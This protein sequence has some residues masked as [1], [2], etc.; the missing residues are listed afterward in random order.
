MVMRLEPH[1]HFTDDRAGALLERARWAAGAF[2]ALDRDATRRIARA[3]AE[4]AYGAA[5]RYAE[6]AVRETGFGVVAHKK[7]K[8]EL[9]S[10]G[11]FEAYE[12][13]DLVGPVVEGSRKIVR[14]AR[15]AGVVLALT[16]STN[17]IAT[18]F[19][20]TELA[21]LTRNAILICPHPRAKDSSVDAADLL[22]QAARAAGAPDGIIQVV[23]D[24]TLPFVE[25][26]M[27]DARVDLVLA[28]GGPSMVAA[29]YRS[30]HPA[31]GVGPGNAPVFVHETA[32][33]AA[34]AKRI[35]ES[36]SFDNSILCTNDSVVLAH[37]PIA[38]RF[39]AA[40]K[41]E[42]T[43]VCS[44]D[45]VDRLR[46]VLWDADGG[47]NVE[48]ALGKDAVTIARLAGFAVPVGTLVLLA[49]ISSLNPEEALAREK[50]APVLGF[51]RVADAAQAGAAARAM[52]RRSG[53]GHSAGFHGTD[54]S[55]LVS[56]ATAS[57]ALRVVVN[58][59]LSQGAAGFGTHLGPTMTVGTGFVGGSSLGENLRPDHLINWA[60]IAF[61][62][63]ASLPAGLGSVVPWTRQPPRPEA[64]PIPFSQGHPPGGPADRRRAPVPE[65]EPVR[66]SEGADLDALRDEIRQLV[67]E[68]LRSALEVA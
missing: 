60:D 13:H 55:A 53:R 5:Q 51:A 9:C 8:N 37:E 21:M 17:P 14:L 10:M 12:G 2:A 67:L 56:F 23:R 49:P 36:K 47:F 24:P 26:L 42:K 45:Q 38:D 48:A 22:M 44:P 31:L 62:S 63:E 33:V 15:P 39:L 65:L 32:D 6:W 66:M 52:M 25:R 1:L 43:H 29:A 28:T 50:L 3:V 16:P 34:A 59:P 18:L 57:P 11:V 40:L 35:V 4:A 19:F 61:A 30:G 20:K 7:L 41:A 27:G 64:A 46:D 58:A 54:E 68:E